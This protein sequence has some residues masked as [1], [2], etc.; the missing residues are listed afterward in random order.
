VGVDGW[1]VDSFFDRLAMAKL[2]LDRTW[3]GSISYGENL[4][5]W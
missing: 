5:R 3:L 2:S 4:V 1:L